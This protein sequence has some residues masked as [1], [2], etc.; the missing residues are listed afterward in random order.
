[1]KSL[2]NNDTLVI[3]NIQ[4]NSVTDKTAE[5]ICKLNN[6]MLLWIVISYG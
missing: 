3:L 2:K 6:D 5:M 1:M 4:G